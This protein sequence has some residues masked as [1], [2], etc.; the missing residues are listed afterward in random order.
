M[1]KK[2]TSVSHSLTESE[3]VSLDAGLRMDGFPALDLWD[4]VI[5]ILHSFKKHP[6]SIK[7]VSRRR[8]QSCVEKSSAQWNPKHQHQRQDTI[9][10]KLMSYLMSITL[11]QSQYLLT[12]KPSST[13][14]KTMKQGSRWSFRAEILRWDTCHGPTELRWFGC[15]TESIWTQK[16]KSILLTPKTNSQTRW[17]KV[18]FTR[19]EWNHLLRLFNIMNLSMS[20]CSHFLS[21]KNS[22]TM[23]KRSMQD[24]KLGEE[25]VLAKS[26][27]VSLESKRMSVNPY[28]MPDSGI[29]CNMENYGMPS[30]NSFL[31]STEKS[32]RDRNKRSTTKK[33]YREV[34]DRLT[35]TRLT[36]HSP[37]I[38]NR[39][40]L[41][42]V[43]SNVQKKT[44]RPED[45]QML[46]LKVNALRCELFMSATMKAAIHLGLDQNAN[47]LTYRNT[48][49]EELKTLLRRNWSWNRNTRSNRFPLS[50]GMLLPEWD[51]LC[52]MAELPS[53]QKQ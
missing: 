47:L 44:K 7:M 19:D 9:T 35:G 3:S 42:N 29:S 48:D 43:F 52:L 4:L 16:S 2:Q 46:D 45:D 49:F 36:H 27:P 17:P 14:L 10:E 38:C 37:K 24:R 30:W 11:S 20:S 6:T 8:Q 26:K 50:N 39:P 41:E 21:I 33:S 40:Y 31:T 5:E 34:Q 51:L 32:G 22:K 12:S 23:S 28:P 53:C 1:C 18:N 15:L 13:F 25:P